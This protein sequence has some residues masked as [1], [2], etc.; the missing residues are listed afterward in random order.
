LCRARRIVFGLAIAGWRRRLALRFLDDLRLLRTRFFASAPFGLL[1]RASFRG[2]A[3]RR[4]FARLALG[5][6]AGFAFLCC[7]PLGLLARPALG[8]RFFS[9]TDCGL[10]S[11]PLGVFA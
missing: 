9:R 8:E 2:R 7:S 11:E 6:L 5:E 4:L 1:P 10:A 3:A